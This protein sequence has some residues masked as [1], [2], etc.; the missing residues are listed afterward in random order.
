VQR[1][2]GGRVAPLRA[3]GSDAISDPESLVKD[4]VGEPSKA[5]GLSPPKDVSTS[6]PNG[7]GTVR[8]LTACDPSP[9]SGQ[10]RLRHCNGYGMLR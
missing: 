5:Q 9:S 1:H 8:I 7:A 10:L 6:T 4:D 2:S 3:S